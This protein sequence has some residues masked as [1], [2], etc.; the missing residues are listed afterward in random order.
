MLLP[1]KSSVVLAAVLMATLLGA[2]SNSER[3]AL[4]RQAGDP[5]A[6]RSASSTPVTVA[7]SERL[8][9]ALLP[10]V[11]GTGSPPNLDVSDPEGSR[12]RL[13][14][15]LHNQVEALNSALT[16]IAAAE[17]APVNKG[18]QVDQVL[19]TT[20][21]QRRN[22]LAAGLA[23]LDAVPLGRP[24]TLK[25]T[26]TAVTSLLVPT[27]GKTLLGLTVPINLQ[28]AIRQA[29]GCQTLDASRDA[30]GPASPP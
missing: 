14:T 25:Y 15:Y 2:C 28:N 29:P 21:S 24:E 23:E 12:Q 7:W 26:L 16:R 13:H 19:V 6:L 8:C 10:V 22:A 17:P 30:T 9:R 4:T 1:M 5:T 11:Q 27:D 18:S 3:P 20:L